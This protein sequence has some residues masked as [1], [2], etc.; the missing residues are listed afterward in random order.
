MKH[1]WSKSS[2]VL[3]CAALFTLT[4]GLLSAGEVI[5]W[6]DKEGNTHFADSMADV[7]PEYQKKVE[8]KEYKNKSQKPK[9]G[10]STAPWNSGSGQMDNRQ[11]SF[12]QEQQLKSFAVPYRAFAGGS[13]RIIIS[14]TFNGSVTAPM[15]LDTGAPGVVLS[16]RLAEKIGVLDGDNGKLL[17]K[18]GGIGGT[19]PAILSVVDKI[20]V[21]DGVSEFVPVTITPQSISSAFE[22]LVGM[23]F[24]ANYQMGIDHRRSILYFQELPNSEERPGGHDE[25]WWRSQFYEFSQRRASWKDFAERAKSS[26]ERGNEYAELAE[27]QYREADRLLRKLDDFAASNSVPM[28]WRQY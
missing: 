3:I 25:I 12:P 19:V 9:T 11:D 15:L 16:M 13:R 8:K 22:G 1:H 17:V 21:G 18:A 6:T 24:M 14:V 23:D 27:K 4:P 20:Q 26:T 5:K 28:K 10:A 2:L 7:P